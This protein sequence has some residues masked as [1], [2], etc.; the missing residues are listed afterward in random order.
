MVSVR[1][2]S[3]RRAACGRGRT[4]RNRRGIE[5]SMIRKAGSCLV[6]VCL[7]VAMLGCGHNGGVVAG[8]TGPEPAPDSPVV[9]GGVL[10]PNGELA[11]APSLLQRFADLVLP[12][13]RALDPRVTNIGAGVNVVFEQLYDTSTPGQFEEVRLSSSPTNL[14]GRFA[15]AIPDYI[16]IGACPPLMLKVGEG[17]TLTRALVYDQSDQDV[18]PESEAVVRLIFSLLADRPAVGIC[19]FSADE[20][21][22]LTAMVEDDAASTFGDS[23]QD[24]NDRVEQ[25]AAADPDVVNALNAFAGR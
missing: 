11:Y 18:R 23:V 2:K 8:L 20:I 25:L 10:A 4:G 1:E 12:T 17:P 19:D 24:L 22:Q 13:A 21:A 9:T 16:V 15:V 14:S 5:V 7:V 3:I 6:Y